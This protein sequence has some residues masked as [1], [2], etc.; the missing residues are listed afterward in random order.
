LDLTAAAVNLG[1]LATV[2]GFLG[3]LYWPL[4]LLSHFRI[5]YIVLGGAGSLLLLVG[6]RRLFATIG[7]V[8]ALVNVYCCIPYYVASHDERSENDLEIKVLMYNVLT[9]N[10]R[11]ADV[12]Q[13]IVSSQADVIFL[14]EVNQK[15][16]DGLR[17]LEAF[18]PYTATKPRDDNFGVAMYSRFEFKDM[19]FEYFSGVP[20]IYV[21]VALN[22]VH[23]NIIGTHPV[24]PASQA[25]TDSRDAHLR[26]LSS[27][28][29]RL[30]DPTIVMGDLN[31]TPFSYAFRSFTNSSKLRDSS[32][33]FGIEATWH[34]K[35]LIF[36]L[37]LDHILVSEEIKVLDRYIGDSLGSDHSM[38]FASLA[39]PQAQQAGAADP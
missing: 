18:Y 16:V 36:A 23:L 12:V 20:S 22:Q 5:Q 27:F 21:R 10:D 34:R 13:A 24:P 19:A 25:G 38:V 7:I 2:L 26:K 4:D 6:K 3:Q 37:P 1:A 15:W 9:S 33:G 17:E 31:A 29:N 28:I 11:Y 14:M 30:D 32:L 35:L 8:S 39:I